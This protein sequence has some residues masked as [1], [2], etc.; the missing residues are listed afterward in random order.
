MFGLL[1]EKRRSRVRQ[2]IRPKHEHGGS[3]AK[4]REK[5]I[6]FPKREE[7]E[8]AIA[9]DHE[10]LAVCNVQDAQDAE[11]Q[12]ESGGGKA[13]KTADQQTENELL[14]ENHYK[15]REE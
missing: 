5:R 1:L 2:P 8:R 9:A 12:R 7:P 4:Q 3:D 10:Q 11:R 14:G 15:S 6:N 13:V